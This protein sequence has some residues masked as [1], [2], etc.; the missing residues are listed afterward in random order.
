MVAAGGGG[1]SYYAG[2]FYGTG[3][4]GGGLSGYTGTILA[5][6]ASPGTGGKTNS[7]GTSYYN[8]NAMTTTIGGFGFGGKSY[9]NWSAA[10][11]GGG[12]YGGGGGSY[13]GAGGGGGSS[14]I[15]GHGGCNSILESST[16]DNII[17]SGSAYRYNG[18]YFTNTNMVD[19][20]IGIPKYPINPAVITK[21]KIFG[22]NDT[23]II[24]KE[25]NMYAINSEIKTIAKISDCTKLSIK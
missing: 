25:R 20:L 2:A 8:I 15:S 11:G 16:S 21:G 7:A 3:G 19:G 18:Y 23:T 10:G 6:D 13:A 14:Y 12:Y 9:I 22:N 5:G 1:G 4:A 24:L 17:H